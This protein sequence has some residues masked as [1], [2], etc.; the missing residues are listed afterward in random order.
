MGIRAP[1]RNVSVATT[2]ARRAIPV[3]NYRQ[4]DRISEIGVDIGKK[5]RSGKRHRRFGRIVG[6]YK[7]AAHIGNDKSASIPEPG[8]VSE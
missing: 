2:F 1:L 4:V 8:I 5:R 3:R 6:D 7:K